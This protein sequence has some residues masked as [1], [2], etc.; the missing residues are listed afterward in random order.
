M[1]D[2]KQLETLKA[3]RAETCKANPSIHRIFELADK[4]IEKGK[5][6]E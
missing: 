6:D 4:A 1:S 5:K 3:I 2:M